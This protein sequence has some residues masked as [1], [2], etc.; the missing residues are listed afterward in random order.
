VI[1]VPGRIVSLILSS[2]GL[3]TEL[4]VL[5]ADTELAVGDRLLLSAKE[6]P[7]P[8]RS[9]K[10]KVSENEILKP[11]IFTN[12]ECAEAVRALE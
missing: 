5:G 12:P 9:V 8:N 2:S 6:A 3:L 10:Q 7:A 1:V 4:E 11:D